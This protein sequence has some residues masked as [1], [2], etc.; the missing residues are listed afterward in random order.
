MRSRS[1]IGNTFCDILTM[2]QSVSFLLNHM[3]RGFGTIQ[4]CSLNASKVVLAKTNS[5]LADIVNE[6]PIVNADGQSILWASRLLGN[7]VPERVAGIDLM[8]RLLERMQGTPLSAYFLGGSETVVRDAVLSIQRQYPNLTIAGYRNGYW[9]DEEEVSIV[10]AI[11]LSGASVLFMAFPSPQKEYFASSHLAE[12]CTKVIFGIGGTLDVIAGKT[13]RA[14]LSWQRNGLEWLYRMI[15]EPRR[16]WRRY[17]LGNAQF[18]FIVLTQ[19]VQT[20]WRG[21]RHH[22]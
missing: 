20:S 11:R 7:P 8:H 18:V 16:M 13:K 1:A 3:T 5:R 21:I 9:T 6:C 10:N 4:H 17:L 19:K 12:N 22:D 2:E 15:Q 14:P